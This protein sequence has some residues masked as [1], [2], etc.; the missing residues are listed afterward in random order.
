MTYA[1]KL[2]SPEWQKKRLEIL[3]RDNFTCTMCG[4]KEKQLHV[5]HKVYIYDNEPWEYLEEFYTTLCYECHD[6]EEK[7]KA[8]FHKLIKHFL[9]KGLT[10]KEL[11]EDILPTLKKYRDK[12][13][14]TSKDI[15]KYNKYV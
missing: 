13:N 1:E 15:V 2:K 14:Y 10:Y 7:D 8:L 11:N 3:Q 5:H 4:S 12:Y 6:I 9:L